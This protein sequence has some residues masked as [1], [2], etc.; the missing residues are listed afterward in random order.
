MDDLK[1]FDEWSALGY[2]IIKGSKAKY[3]D[4]LPMFTPEQVTKV[5]RRRSNSHMRYDSHSPFGD[6]YDAGG[7]DVGMGAD[8]SH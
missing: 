2:K 8:F 5:P 1:T 3:V 7:A 6:D 4:C